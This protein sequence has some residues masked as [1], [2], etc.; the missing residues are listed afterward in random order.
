M[1]FYPKNP[2]QLFVMDLEAVC[3]RSRQIGI[4]GSMND[5]APASFA[6][7]DEFKQ[8]IPFQILIAD[9]GSAC[10]AT[11]H[12]PQ[13]NE[14]FLG[15]SHP[16]TPFPGKNLPEGIEKNTYFSRFY[17]FEKA[18]PYN[19]VQRTGAFCLGYPKEETQ[20][21]IYPNHKEMWIIDDLMECPKIHFVTGIVDK[22]GDDSKVIVSYGISDCISRF[23]EIDKSEIVK[24][25]WFPD[26]R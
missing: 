9:R 6:T 14:L 13:G 1:E 8:N 11:I 17:V 26:D 25:L 21:P 12:D 18:S 10:C 24:M 19:I 3:G 7:I 15:V 5:T 22:V 16:K 4:Q 23:I 20:N 2:H